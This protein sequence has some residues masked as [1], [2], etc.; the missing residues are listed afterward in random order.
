MKKLVVSTAALLLCSTAALAQSSGNFASA[1][2]TQQCKL[3]SSTGALSGGAS[4]H[5]LTTSIQTPNS[6]QTT[7]LIRPSFVTGLYG[8]TYI[9]STQ[10]TASQTAE[11]VVSVLLDGKPVLPSTASDPTVTYD[12][13]FQQI[14]TQM[15]TQ[16]AECQ[17]NDKCDFDMI[18]STLSAH[19]FDFV[20]PNVGQGSHQ[21]D[22]SWTMECDDGSGSPSASKC[23][24][25][26]ANNTAAACVG[27][28]VV[29][30]TQTKAFSQSGGVTIQ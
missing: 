28:G 16:I 9:T 10:S 29:T 12:A 3:S 7:L 13:R 30:V 26:F 5:L 23:S 27:P 11:V 24:T 17:N 21:L 6:S 15:W 14:S 8:N 1:L 2:S 22:V 25:T 19:S 18:L 20:A 4:N